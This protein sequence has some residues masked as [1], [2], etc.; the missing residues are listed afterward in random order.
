ML[1]TIGLY[2]NPIEAHIVRGRIEAEGIPAYVQHEHHSWAKW[3]ISLALG[4]VKVQVRQ[5]DVK[6][7]VAVL[8]NIQ[9]GEYALVEEADTASTCC[10]KCGGTEMER[11]NWSWK[12]ALWGVMFFSVVIPYTIYRVKCVECKH[13]WTQKELRGYPLW[14]SVFAVL[15]ISAA[16]AAIERTLYYVCRINLLSEVCT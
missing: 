4:Y 13:S 14:V 9:S 10:A 16:F 3:T 11:V 2:L 6:A 1:I 12:M 8:E 5:E 7:A 15:L